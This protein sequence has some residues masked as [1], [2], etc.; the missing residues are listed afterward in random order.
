MLQSDWPHLFNLVKEK[1][2]NLKWKKN[3]KDLHHAGKAQLIIKL[4]HNEASIPQ[5]NKIRK[6]IIRDQLSQD[7]D[8]LKEL[9]MQG[10]LIDNR[11][12]DY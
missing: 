10:R 11:Y 6:E 5:N 3:T 7:L 12:A 9:P 4:K 1:N 8:N 2:A